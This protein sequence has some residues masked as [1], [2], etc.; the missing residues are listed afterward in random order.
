MRPMPKRPQQNEGFSALGLD[1]RIVEALTTLGYEEPTPIQQ[2]TITPL[3]DGRDLLGQAATGTGKTAAFALPILQRFVD[4]GGPGKAGPLAVVLVPTRELAMQ[5]AEAVHRYGKALNVR[6]LPIY[7]GQPIGRQIYAMRSGVDVVIATPGRALDHLRRGTLQM[8][9]VKIVVLDEADEMLDM[10]F[11][12]DIEAV[13]KE[14]P[15]GRQTVLFSATM[16]PRIESIAKRHQK[17]PIRI[18]I[19]KPVAKPGEAPKV[20][21]QAYVLPRAQKMEALGRILD[22]EEP[23]AAIVFCRTRTEVDE[24]TETLNARGYKAQALHG[25]MTQFD[26]DKVMR[27]LRSGEAE[28]LI[29]T[30]V[31]ARGLDVDRL[32]HVVNYDLPAAPEAYVHR[33]GRV[34][35]AGR[36]GVAITLVEPREHHALRNIERLTKH[37]IE[38]AK[39][40]TV[41]DLRA[42][43][44]DNTIAALREVLAANESEHFRV[45]VDAL[46]NE[47]DAVEI[48]MAAVKL[49]DAA[50]SGDATEE[51]VPEEPRHPGRG[52]RRD[53]PGPNSSPGDMA[54]IYIGIGKQANVRP[55]DLVGAIAN[56]AGIAGG[57]IGAIQITERFSIVEVPGEVAE[58]V[59]KALGKSNIRGKKVQVRRDK[60]R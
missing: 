10:G 40:P 14:S 17:D 38:V 21:Q 34:G 54:R 16:P 3:I 35:R 36:E 32:T 29:A 13:L 23:A 12:E 28:L 47:Y 53:G 27:R 41:A 46:S 60:A 25:G 43:R 56:E 22:L 33:I 19:N 31:A 24:L 49:Y 52:V 37:K 7:G 8:G 50:T 57:L 26:R 55:Q 44:M 18:K 45:V 5:V 30:D 58:Q 1:A 15:E 6:V 51:S 11:Q 4:A 48:A 20:R 42:K 39:V 9:G 2:E 59:I